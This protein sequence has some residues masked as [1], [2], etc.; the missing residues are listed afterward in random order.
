MTHRCDT[1]IFYSVASKHMTSHKRSLTNL[2]QK[3]SPHKVKLSD[4][5]QYPIN[6]VG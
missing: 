5:Y 6:G 3:D 1:C 4:D 2:V